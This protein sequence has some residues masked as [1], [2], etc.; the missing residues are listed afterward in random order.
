MH[1]P[2]IPQKTLPA[3]F[4]V[5]DDG[6]LYR[7]VRVAG[8]LSFVPVRLLY[9]YHHRTIRSVADMKACLRA[10]KYAWPGGY[11]CYFITSDGEI[12]SFEAVREELTQVMDAI[13]H[14]LRSG[15]KVVGMACTAED[16]ET[17]RCC[18]TGKEID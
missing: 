8:G 18:H 10:G 14:N 15:W 6:N 5:G 3:H 16:D 7:E 2:N 1:T 4:M 11:A 9:R 12:L 17:A 13:K